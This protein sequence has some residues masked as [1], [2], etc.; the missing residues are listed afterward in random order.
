MRNSADTASALRA[1]LAR[2]TERLSDAATFVLEAAPAVGF[3]VQ[4]GWDALL[5]TIA[6]Q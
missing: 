2:M 6:D 3:Q 5:A 4:H 1:K